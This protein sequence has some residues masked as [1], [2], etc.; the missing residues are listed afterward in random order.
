MQQRKQ[1]Q[2]GFTLLEIMI[3]VVILGVLAS[4]ML[5][6]LMGN[7]DKADRQ[8]ALSDIVT[9]ENA[10]EMYRL[11]NNIYPSTAQGLKALVKKPEIAP[12]PRNY[13][14]DG[15]VRR[16]P[17]DPWGNPYQLKSPGQHGTLDIYSFGPGGVEGE[18]N[19]ANWQLD[20]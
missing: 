9:L 8:K 7:K 13:R 5:P 11:D 3:V 15:Y 19:I 4:L 18:D 17:K 2:R 12:I 14:D 1:N 6:S 10:L 20:E 16:L